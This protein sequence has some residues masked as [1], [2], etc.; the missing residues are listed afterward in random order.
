MPH[1]YSRRLALAV[2]AILLIVGTVVGLSPGTALA[3]NTLLSSDP[4]DGATLAIAPVQITWTFDNP[5]PLETMT[6]TL[7][8]ASGARSDLDGSVHGRAR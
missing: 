3:H 4:V 5:V 2:L 7:I 1:S 8:D 6:V